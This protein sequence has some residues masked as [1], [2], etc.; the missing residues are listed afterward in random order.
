MGDEEMSSFHRVFTS[1]LG[2]KEVP[3]DPARGVDFANTHFDRAIVFKGF[4]FAT[5]ADFRWATFRGDADF[6]SAMFLERA[7]FDTATFSGSAAFNE[8]T[9]S[10]PTHFGSAMFSDFALF[11]G[12][13]FS[14]IADFG[15]ADILRSTDF[16]SATFS[17][18]SNFGSAAFSSSAFFTRAT[19]DITDFGLATFSGVAGFGSAKFFGV[20]S[21]N[22][23]RFLH[24][25]DFINTEFTTQAI[26]ANVHFESSVPDFRG[27]RMHEATEW[28]GVKW[29]DPPQ[30]EESA[31]AQVYAYERLKQEM[32]RLKKHEDEQFFFRK[33]LRAR[34]K[35]LPLGSMPWLVN[36]AYEAS[37]DYGQSV[38][39]P[40]FWLLVVFEFGTAVF[41]LFPVFNGAPMSIP[42][43]AGLSAANIFSFLPIKREIMT[44]EMVAGLSAAAQF[45]GTV[46]SLLGVVLLFLLGL[47]LR[48]QFRMK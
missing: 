27:A 13:T 4:L 17:G 28:H 3:P 22:S 47:A 46:Q 1:R 8:A 14:D 19:F 48:N 41:A 5:P 23:A 11:G 31:Q 7:R 42:L 34:R 39:W 37:S 18:L 45:V 6:S 35:L 30:D 25:A 16:N 10:G 32:E 29:P 40:I 20:T 26:F 21:L 38:V 24:T 44:A 43:A 36:Y 2:R 12:A 15:R 33:E 9:F